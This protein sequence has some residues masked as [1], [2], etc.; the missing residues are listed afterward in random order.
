M[1][2]TPISSGRIHYVLIAASLVIIIAGIHLAHD[3]LVPVLISIFLSVLGTPPVRWLKR[4]RVPIGIAVLIVISVILL[5]IILLATIVGA[6]MSSLASS[7]PVYQQRLQEHITALTTFLSAKGIIIP[8]DMLTTSMNSNDMANI[9]T[10]FL[11]GIGSGISML[12]VILLT[13]SFIL[14]EAGSFP[15]KIR[16]AV[17]NPRAVFPGFTAFVNEM[18]RFM[19]FQ[20]LYG[21]ITGVIITLW[22]WLFGVEYAVLLGLITF[23]LCYIPMWVQQLLLS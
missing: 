15:N 7:M 5:I 20:T 11:S 6:S 1:Q 19:V 4:R 9:A 13:V 21:L 17:G 16:A 14:L 8:P 10:S 18:Q 23:I 12:V 2:S 3:F 22:L